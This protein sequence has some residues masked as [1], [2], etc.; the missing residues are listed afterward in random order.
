MYQDVVGIHKVSRNMWRF[1]FM[2]RQGTS[3]V[4]TLPNQRKGN[5]RFPLAR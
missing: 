3:V 1:H 4:R 5:F 2:P